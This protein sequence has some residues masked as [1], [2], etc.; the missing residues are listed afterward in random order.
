MSKTDPA[1]QV[2]CCDWQTHHQ[3]L[4]QIRRTVFIEEQSVPEELEW[5]DEDVSAWHFLAYIEDQAVGAARLLKSGQIGRM[6]VLKPYRRQGIGSALLH[7][8]ERT[9]AENQLQHLFLHAQTYIQAF[10]RSEGYSPRGDTFMDAGI[11]HIEM[12]KELPVLG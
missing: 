4:E 9:A 11:P 1:L 6:S 2:I 8:A 7:Q 12:Y 10:Y 3:A 5:D